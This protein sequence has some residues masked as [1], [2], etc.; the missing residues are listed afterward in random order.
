[1]SE[2]RQRAN[3]IER[4]R[5]LP[6][7]REQITDNSRALLVPGRRKIEVTDADTSLKV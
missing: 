6:D 7:N 4:A 5:L 2:F 1:M 3:F